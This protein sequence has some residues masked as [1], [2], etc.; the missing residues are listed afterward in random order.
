M[1]N[2]TLAKYFANKFWYGFASIVAI[3]LLA[4]VYNIFFYETINEALQLTNV[5]QSRKVLV[6]MLRGLIIS[7]FYYFIIYSLHILA[8]KQKS[9]IEIEQLKQAQLQANISSLKEQLSP[10]F[11]FNTLN[12]LST[13]TNE[14][15]VKDFVNELANV[16]RYLLQYKEENTATIQKEL[17]FIESYLYIIKTRLEQAIEIDIKVTDQV[18]RSMIPPLT[19]QILIENAVKH[20]IAA[21]HKPL[22]INIYNI[23]DKELVIENNMQP[24]KTLA[25]S[26]GIGLDNIVKRYA[27]LFGKEITIEKTQDLFLV[28]L[29]IVFE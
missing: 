4:Y 29:P 28:K 17:T 5:P 11:L 18:L 14:K 6:I 24:K 23:D 25:D 10:H 22:M 12:T 7:G 27:L 26:T 9:K 2:T 21:T 3:G 13:L 8:E 1:E 20:N 19:L 16:Y 15:P